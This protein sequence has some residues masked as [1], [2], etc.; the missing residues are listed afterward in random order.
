[1]TDNVKPVRLPARPTYINSK[2]FNTNLIAVHKT[3]TVLQ[4][5][6]SSYFGMYTLD[7]SKTL[8]YEFHYK[9]IETKYGDKAA[10]YCS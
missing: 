6:R 3:K 2:I 10:V 5:N 7:P 1:M 9:L 8:R 4:L